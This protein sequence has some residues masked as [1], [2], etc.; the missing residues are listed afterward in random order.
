MADKVQSPIS[1][2]IPSYNAD[3]RD[4]LNTNRFDDGNF[5]LQ[6]QRNL[7]PESRSER[8]YR[9]NYTIK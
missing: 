2:T 5:E 7:L 9:K 6:T 8:D 3:Q 4:E 1:I